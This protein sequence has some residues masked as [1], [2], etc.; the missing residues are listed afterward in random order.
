MVRLKNR[1]L[2]VEVD[3][4]DNKLD[5]SFNELAILTAI[6]ESVAV[7]FGDYGLGCN[8]SS[9]QV[10][11][12]SPFT[13]TCIVRCA[14]SENERVVTSLALMTEVKGR[15]AALRLL[16]IAGTLGACKDAAAAHSAARL[17]QLKLAPRQQAA[18]QLHAGISALE[19]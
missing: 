11:Y 17:P 12:Y 8:L 5:E 16:R 18:E 14:T 6:R 4:K 9:L 15:P 2:L 7:N 19:L 13:G 1:Y 3:Y 10:K